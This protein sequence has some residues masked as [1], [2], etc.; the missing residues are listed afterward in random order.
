MVVAGL[1]GLE[2]RALRRGDR[3]RAGAS[4]DAGAGA[5]ADAD[6]SASASAGADAVAVVAGPDAGEGELEAL[7]GSA[8]TVAAASDRTGTRLDGP[9]PRISVHSAHDR[10]SG[11]MVRGAI[12]RTPAGLIVLGPDHPT[13]GGYPVVAVLREAAMDAFFSTPVGRPVRFT[14]R[15]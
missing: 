8:F 12:E 14:L 5:S 4:A 13:T 7:V 9:L 6:A 15:T 3:L 1:G 2:G 11:P 10:R